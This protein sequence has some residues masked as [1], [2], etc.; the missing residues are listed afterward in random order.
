MLTGAGDRAFCAGADIS[1]AGV[2]KTG[3]EYWA[4]LD[5]DGFGGCRCARR[6]T[7]R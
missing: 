1:A 2:D 4:D 6:S 7:C 5:P 3:L